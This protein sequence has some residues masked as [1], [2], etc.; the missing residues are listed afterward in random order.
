M[1][2]IGNKI[3]KKGWGNGQEY[4]WAE[5]GIRVYVCVREKK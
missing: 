4:L 3:L 1:G 5:S 2:L